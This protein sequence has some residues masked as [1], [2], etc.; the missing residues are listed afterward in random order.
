MRRLLDAPTE[1]LREPLFRLVFI[2][3]SVSSF[4]GGLMPVALTFAVLARFHSATAL[5]DVLGAQTIASILLYI[6]GGVAGGIFAPS[7]MAWCRRSS[8]R[9]TCRARTP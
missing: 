3:Q 2:G 9:S 8:A 7:A 6:T 4:G 1:A 5:G